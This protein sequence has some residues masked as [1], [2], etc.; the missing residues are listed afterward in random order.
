MYPKARAAAAK[1]IALDPSL[2]EAHALLG[3]VSYLYDWKWGAA[4]GEFLLVEGFGD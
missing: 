3:E 2:P 4:E 1:A